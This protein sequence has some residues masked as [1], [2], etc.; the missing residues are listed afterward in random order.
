MRF[1][2]RSAPMFAAVIATAVLLSGCGFGAGPG[3]RD[4]SVVVTGN[5]GSRLYGT[6]VERHVAGAET[7]MSLLERHFKVTTKYGGAFVESIDGHTGSSSHR[8]WF[9]YVNGIEAPD[10][11]SATD[12]HKGDH[13]WWDLHDWTATDSIPA[14]VG[15]YPEPFTNGSGGR[16][17]PTLLNCGSGVQRACDEV[18]SNLHRY[19]VKAADQV[20]GTGSGSDSLAVVVG[21]WNQIK[22]V[23]AAQLIA[24]G[25]RESGVYAHFVGS[26]ALELDNPRGQV[27]RTLRGSVGLIA[28]TGEASLGQPT[29]FVTG[30]DVAAVN[31]AAKD[32]TAAKLAHH[33]AVATDGSTVIPVPVA[34]GS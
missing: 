31:A 17:F 15:S 23:I 25:P 33:F 12:V 2:T 4:A 20:L 18:G 30:T 28:A 27:E 6:A 16:E 19:G 1:R 14:V 26:S 34:P 7:V 24:S 10:G 8:D 22:G 9:Y 3:T 29:W 21:T 13:I 5:F 11:A 32:F